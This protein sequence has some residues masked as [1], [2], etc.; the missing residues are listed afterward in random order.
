MSP[1]ISPS[2]DVQAGSN[3]QFGTILAAEGEGSQSSI[4]MVGVPRRII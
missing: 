2:G 3:D 4:P 1:K